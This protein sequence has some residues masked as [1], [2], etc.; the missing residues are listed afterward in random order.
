LIPA[1]SWR[2]EGGGHILRF[3]DPVPWTD[4]EDLDEEIRANTL[5]YNRARE[6]MILRHPEQW[7]W[8]HRRW[9]LKD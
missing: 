9:K 7:F 2:E 8:M 5:A 4:R 6:R 3:E 1:H